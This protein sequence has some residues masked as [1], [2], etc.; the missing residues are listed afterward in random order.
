MGLPHYIAYMIIILGA[1]HD[2]YYHVHVIS[3]N[4]AIIQ[5]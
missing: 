2:L 1:A 3:F 5:Y 4:L